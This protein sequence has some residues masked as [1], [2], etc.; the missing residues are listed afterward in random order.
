MF[1]IEKDIPIPQISHGPSRYDELLHI[2]APGDS[3][4]LKKSEAKYLYTR[5]RMRKRRIVI[6]AEGDKFRAWY[7]GPVS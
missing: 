3:V 6:R 7:V 5:G 1:K 4:L 2:M